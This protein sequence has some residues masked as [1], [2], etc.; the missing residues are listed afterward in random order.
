MRELRFSFLP[1]PPHNRGSP[2][3]APWG[4][5]YSRR[6][7][8]HPAQSVDILHSFSLYHIIRHCPASPCSRNTQAASQHA[9]R[10]QNGPRGHEPFAPSG[11]PATF[12]P[13]V[14]LEA[15]RVRVSRASPR[16]YTSGKRRGQ[17]AA[18]PEP[19]RAG[20][21]YCGTAEDTRAGSRANAVNLIVA[22]AL[23]DRPPTG[24]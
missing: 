12:P 10:G 24:R 3:Q 5:R 17:I 18:R 2:P 8:T 4:L 19:Q 9:R 15:G 13:P 7:A 14:R 20:A 6:R 1:S 11:D 23:L 21:P 16:H 22:A